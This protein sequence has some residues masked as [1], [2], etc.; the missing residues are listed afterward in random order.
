M[1]RLKK[2]IDEVVPP[3]CPTC[4]I[5]MR[6]TRSALVRDEDPAMIQHTFHC[7]SCNRIGETKTEVKEARIPP[8][9]LSLPIDRLRAA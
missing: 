6:W 5:E 2:S 4:L 8:N 9:K 1:D 3:I 7:P